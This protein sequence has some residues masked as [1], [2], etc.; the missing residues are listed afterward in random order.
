MGCFHLLLGSLVQCLNYS[1]LMVGI[2]QIQDWILTDNNYGVLK[3]FD[4]YDSLM[5]LFLISMMH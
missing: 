3:K 2:Y 1:I 4:D 5:I